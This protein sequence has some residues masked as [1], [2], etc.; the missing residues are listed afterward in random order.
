MK[1]RYVFI[2]PLDIAENAA[3]N[4]ASG[5]SGR[6][7]LTY[8]WSN[9]AKRALLQMGSDPSSSPML[10]RAPI[11]QYVLDSRLLSLPL[12]LPFLHIKK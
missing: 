3:L 5:K 4:S 11:F 2:A 12:F 9:S 7:F 10:D 1:K 8:I 6:R